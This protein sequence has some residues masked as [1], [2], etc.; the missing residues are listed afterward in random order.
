MLARERELC[1][2]Q[3]R[4]W[5][6]STE[7]LEENLGAL[8]QPIEAGTRR[9]RGG[10]REPS[11]LDSARG[12]RSDGQEE[13]RVVNQQDRVGLKPFTR[14]VGRSGGTGQNLSRGSM[15]V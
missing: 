11:F 1:L 3:C 13:G 9:E 14:T 2:G 5:S 7:L 6:G 15:A 4:R 10:H 8:P 12:P